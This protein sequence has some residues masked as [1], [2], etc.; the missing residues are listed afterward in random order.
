MS[1][2]KQS[3]VIRVLTKKGFKKYSGDHVNLVLMVDGKEVD[4]RTHVSNSKKF[5]ISTNNRVFHA[6]KAQLHLTRNQLDRLLSCPMTK[7]DL[8]K[9][10]KDEGRIP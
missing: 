4:I 3:E 9:I 6:M 2:W 10:L 7:E 5:T 1:S 8:I